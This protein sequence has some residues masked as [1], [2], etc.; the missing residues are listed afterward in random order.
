ME[1]TNTTNTAT[2]DTGTVNTQTEET[3]TMSKADFNKK[4][5]SETDKVRTE[6]SAKIKTLEDKVKEL[7]PIQKSEMEINLEKRLAEIEAREKAAD[8]KEALAKNN[9]P[10]ELGDFLKP[11]TD[12]SALATAFKNVVK[13]AI[14][15][16]ISDNGYKPD[17]H[18][19]GDAITK[20]DFARMNMSDRETLYRENPTLYKSLVKQ[21]KK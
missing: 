18:K 12:M 3:V 20:E 9:I 13:S 4:I 17:G 21:Q 8:F 14:D 11:D 2:V 15:K 10:G 19:S 1:N 16:Y 6:Y 5:Q 7:T